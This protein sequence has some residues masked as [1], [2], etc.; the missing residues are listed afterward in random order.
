MGCFRSR[1]LLLVNYLLNHEIPLKFWIDY[2]RP[3]RSCGKVMFWH[4]SVIQFTEGE[5]VADTP[6][7]DT[8]P[9]QTAPP[10]RY[11]PQPRQ[12]PPWTDTPRSACW[13][14]RATS[15]RYASYWNAYLLIFIIC[16]ALKSQD[17]NE[18]QLCLCSVRTQEVWGSPEVG[19]WWSRDILPVQYIPNH[20]GRQTFIEQSIIPLT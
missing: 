13:E 16:W 3:Q 2:Y 10:G 20:Q 17:F 11:P 12:T 19:S 7:A 8:L 15:G 1:H 9:G 5:W 14:I 4:L 6:R 18:K